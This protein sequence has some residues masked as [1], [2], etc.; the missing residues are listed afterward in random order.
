M[1]DYERPLSISLLAYLL[2]TIALIIISAAV[3]V[4]FYEAVFWDHGLLHALNSRVHRLLVVMVFAVLIFG[5][6][7]GLLKS[8][9]G[10]RRLLMVLCLV[11]GTHGVSVALSDLLRGLLILGICT[12]VIFHMLTS[13]V[14]A[15][16]QPMDS[17]KA[18]EAINALESYRRSRAYK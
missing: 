10:G 12:A 16:F 11:A 8:S 6:G 17:R 18:V 2:F 3:Y 5:S 7:I 1:V 4:F 14:S 9:P 13:T 15:V